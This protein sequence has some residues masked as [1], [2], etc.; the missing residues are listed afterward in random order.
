MKT[1]RATL[2][3]TFALIAICSVATAKPLPSTK[4]EK[5]GMSTERLNR[6]TE[7]SKRYVDEGKLAGVITMVARD[8]KLVH[9]EAVGHKGADDP[10]PLRKDDLFRIYSM[11]KPITAAAAMQLYEQGKFH[12]SDPVSKFVP[13]LKEIKV[14]TEDGDKVSVKNAMTMH[15]LLTHTA[16]FSYGFNPK[17]DPVDKAYGEAKI[18]D[19]KNLDDFAT[20]ISDLPLKFQPGDQWHYSIAVD[21]TG[22]VIERIS[23][24][25]FDQ[26]L[27]ENIFQPLGMKDTF[28]EV[29][30]DKADRFLPNHYWDAENNKLATIE[31]EGS[32][33]MSNY[34]DVSLFSGRL[35]G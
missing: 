32:S 1:K 4:A 14:L 35:A 9:F 22:L 34:H 30:E 5:V 27:E 16:G 2:F 17:G 25:S 18:W 21:V 19:T 11:S 13:E 20:V 15:H 23:G 33:A 29:P 12:L 31:E 3:T 28:F 24:L 6:I 8:G 7:M 10:R 26:Y